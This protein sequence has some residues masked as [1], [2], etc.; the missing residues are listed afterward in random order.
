MALATV[1]PS[2]TGKLEQVRAGVGR[3]AAGE[4]AE[5]TEQEGGRRREELGAE[6]EGE[7]GMSELKSGLSIV[8]IDSHRKAHTQER[9][10][11]G[12][13]MKERMPLGHTHGHTHAYTYM[14]ERLSTR[15]RLHMLI[16]T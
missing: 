7:V 14:K 9:S 2:F 8:L 5:V 1:G 12:L 6:E 3:T 13:Y 10:Y 15:C 4:G 16:H 11:P